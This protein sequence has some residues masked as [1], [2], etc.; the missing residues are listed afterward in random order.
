MTELHDV[1]PPLADPKLNRVKCCSSV[2]RRST[3]NLVFLVC[4]SKNF[5]TWWCHGSAVRCFQVS[6]LSNPVINGCFS[7]TVCRCKLVYMTVPDRL[8]NEWPLILI[9]GV[10]NKTTINCNTMLPLGLTKNRSLTNSARLSSLGHISLPLT[11]IHWNKLRITISL[12]RRSV[13]S[14]GGLG[15][16]FFKTERCWGDFGSSFFLIDTHIFSKEHES[17]SQKILQYFGCSCEVISQGVCLNLAD[18]AC[19]RKSGITF[20]PL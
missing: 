20:M 12:L 7:V 17:F 8:E 14:G 5:V 15:S 16:I 9:R 13:C 11:V 6:R 3:G 1:T 18:V 2:R 19:W 4:Q 10:V